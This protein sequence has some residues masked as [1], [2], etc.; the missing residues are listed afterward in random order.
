MLFTF[1]VGRKEDAFTLSLFT[2]VGDSGVLAEFP[3]TM[4]CVRIA[5]GCVAE[6][7]PAPGATEDVTRLPL[8]GGIGWMIIDTRLA[9]ASLFDWLLDDDVL[10]KAADFPL[11]PG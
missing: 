3:L 7:G 5:G 9:A 1:C 2:A 4:D 10:T 6:A 11:A 8:K